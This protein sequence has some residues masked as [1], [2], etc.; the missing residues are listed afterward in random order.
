MKSKEE[1]ILGVESWCNGFD[2]T[3]KSEMTV[4]CVIGDMVKK[5]NV[6]L[7]SGTRQNLILTL[8]QSMINDNDFYD[9]TK[10]AVALYDRFVASE[11]KK[12]EEA[13]KE[14]PKKMF[15]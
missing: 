11:V 7:I 2:E 5:E 15:S 14:N 6:D 4:F 9:V 10:E 1:I 13:K 3:A 8:A 12:A